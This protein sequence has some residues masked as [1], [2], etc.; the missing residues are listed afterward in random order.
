M[1]EN[2]SELELTGLERFSH[3]EDRIY[4]TVEAFKSIRKENETLAAENQKLKAEVD[5]LHRERSAD[6]H[7]LAQ[8]QKEREALRERVEKALNLLAAL[9]VK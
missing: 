5:A 9:E 8:L 1:T 7:N 4:R 2:T 6:E 3:L